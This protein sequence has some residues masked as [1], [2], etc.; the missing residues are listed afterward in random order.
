MT[1][2]ILAAAFA[3]IWPPLLLLLTLKVFPDLLGKT[4]F[5]VIE[6]TSE[7][8]LARLRDELGRDTA[9]RIETVKADLQGAYSTLKTSV[10][11]LTAG[12]SGLRTETIS[13]A[14]V[15]WSTLLKLRADLGGVVTFE[16]VFLPEE[17]E[18]ALRSQ[19]NKKMLSMI[20][21]FEDGSRLHAPTELSISSGVEEG[22]IFVGDRLWLLF[23]V[24]RA[25]Y[26]RL[27][28][29]AQ[30]TMRKRE[31]HNWRTDKGIDSLLASVLPENLVTIAKKQ[32][33]QGLQ[34]LLG[35]LEAEFL[36]EAMR[37]MSGSKAVA[38]SLA[39]IQATLLFH[40]QQLS[41][42]QAA[43]AASPDSLR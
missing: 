21:P 38:D 3:V 22:R 29:L 14:R 1:F 43:R 36:T 30:L 24:T 12:Q 25:I 6:H 27:G 20:A 40:Q 5:K 34:M 4:L 37:V 28:Y 39:D 9:L 18:S 8:R 31:Y 17:I 13:A 19:S 33:V 7:V 10:D 15:M 41:E 32:K 35:Q 42:Q 16:S 2:S 23:Y 26:L 11:F